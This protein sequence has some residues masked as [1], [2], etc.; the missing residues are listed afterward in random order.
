MRIKTKL[1]L[2]VLLVLLVIAAVS[3]TSIG[4]MRSVKK[5]LVYLTERSTPFQIRTLESHKAVQAVTTDLTRL[6]GAIVQKILDY[7]K[8]ER[9]ISTPNSSPRHLLSRGLSSIRR[10]AVVELRRNRMASLTAA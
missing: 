2:N 10:I 6:S 9:D 1:T 7:V 8:R 3:V 5:N 4:S